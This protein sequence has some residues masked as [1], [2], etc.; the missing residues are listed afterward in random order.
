[1]DCSDEMDDDIKMRYYW[2]Y[3]NIRAISGTNTRSLLNMLHTM[4][5]SLIY[6]A[7]LCDSISK[8]VMSMRLNDTHISA[9]AIRYLSTAYACASVKISISDDIWNRRQ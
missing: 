9:F 8:S 6:L 1:M 2:I 7:H 5:V 3:V 4:I